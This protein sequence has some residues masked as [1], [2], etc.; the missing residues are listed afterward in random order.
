MY[1]VMFYKCPKCK[2]PIPVLRTPDVADPEIEIACFEGLVCK[3]EGTT[4]GMSPV[5][6]MELEWDSTAS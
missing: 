3:W 4:K 1:N 6:V 2:R 5:T